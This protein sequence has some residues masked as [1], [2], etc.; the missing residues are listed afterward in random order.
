M[1]EITYRELYSSVEK[2]WKNP[3]NDQRDDKDGTTLEESME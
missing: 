2:I 1:R 3:I